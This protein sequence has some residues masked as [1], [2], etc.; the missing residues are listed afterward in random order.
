MSQN[1][2]MFLYNFIRL[3]AKGDFLEL[4]AFRG[5]TSYLIR[6]ALHSKYK[7]YTIDSF[8]DPDFS[9]EPEYNQFSVSEKLSKIGKDFVVI[10]S[11]A[12][13]VKWNTKVWGT[14]F[15]ANHDF[16]WLV[17]H[18]HIFA[19]FTEY[20]F[21]HDYCDDHQG[22]VEFIKWLKYFDK[23]EILYIVDTLVVIRRK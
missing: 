12:E 18:F 16:F 19:P 1:E 11:R 4:G 22:V 17:L 3:N 15:D 5:G 9:N 6:E 23:Y 2:Q 14:L 21:V 10:S 13:H 20:M 8:D 7:F